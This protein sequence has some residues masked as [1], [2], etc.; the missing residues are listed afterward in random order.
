MALGLQIEI[1]CALVAVIAGFAL[2][3]YFRKS[4]TPEKRE[5]QRRLA[6]NSEGRLGDALI[7]EVTDDALFY[8]Y[9]VRGVQYAASQDFGSLRDLMPADPERLIGRAGIKYLTRNPA[10]S[11]LL[12]EEWSGLRAPAARSSANG[13]AIGHQAEN[14]TL[15]EGFER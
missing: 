9:E 12:C 5:H 14:P 3:A 10:N 8:T 15:A 13:D 11:I 7:T 1:L 4:I 6:V 2:W